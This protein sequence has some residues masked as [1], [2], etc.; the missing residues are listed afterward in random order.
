[1]GICGPLRASTR[2][3]AHLLASHGPLMATVGLNWPLKGLTLA[4]HGPLRASTDFNNGPSTGL[5][6]ATWALYG[7]RMSVYRLLRA[8]WA[9][10]GPLL[11]ST[12]IYRASTTCGPLRA[13]W[14]S[15]NLYGPLRAST[16]LSWASLRAQTSTPTLRQWSNQPDAA[17]QRT[18]SFVVFCP[19]LPDLPFHK[20]GLDRG[21]G[22]L[23]CS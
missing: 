7:P 10:H 3:Y 4:F 17:A 18:A 19:W 16:G 9:F 8:T 15:Y 11:A 21:V 12:H 20:G 22:V 13:T 14:A 2:I 6:W 1:M 23:A 5:A